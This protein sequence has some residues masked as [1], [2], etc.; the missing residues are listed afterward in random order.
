MSNS[1]MSLPFA[2]AEHQNLFAKYGVHP[3]LV[4]CVGGIRCVKELIENKVDMAT[5]SELP[6][7]FNAYETSNLSILGTFAQNNDDLKLIVSKEMA[8]KKPGDWQDRRVGVVMKSASHYYMDVALLYH[9]IDP[10]SVKLVGLTPEELPKAISSGKVDAVSVWEPYGYL[11]RLAGANNVVVLKT[12]KLYQQ[13]F[14]LTTTK[15]FSKS[16]NE[17]ISGVL[18]ALNAAN[19]FIRTHPAQAQQIMIKHSN[20]DQEFVKQNW[21]AYRFDL[22]LQQSLI[23]TME[24]EARW[25]VRENHV[26]DKGKT[27][28]VSKLIDASHLNR[29]APQAIDFAYK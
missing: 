17:R 19:E 11:T 16:N 20:L 8:A 2:V 7:L 27:P 25:M 15:D 18:R 10:R 23:T 29:V 9:G 6:V 3:E 1:P 26:S 12:P 4:K 13:S 14:I 21:G 5:S 22:A 24:G 28:D